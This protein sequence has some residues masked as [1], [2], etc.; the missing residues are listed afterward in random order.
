[1]EHCVYIA[2][3]L[4]FFAKRVK[5]RHIGDKIARKLIRLQ[6]IFETVFFN[7]FFF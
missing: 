4:R 1:M 7:Q 5:T 6:I 2:L 3:A